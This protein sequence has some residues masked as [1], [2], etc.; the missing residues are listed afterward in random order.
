MLIIINYYYQCYLLQARQGRTT[1]VIAHRLSTVQNADLIAVIQEGT[2]V[3]KGRH[4]ELMNID[5]LY[6]QLVT[7][8]VCMPSFNL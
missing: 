6:R 4:D 3:E 2:I 1:I 7:L 8:Q 5:G